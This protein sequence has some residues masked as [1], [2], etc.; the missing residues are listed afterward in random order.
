MFKKEH[1]QIREKYK[2]TDQANHWLNT[3][4]TTYLSA[5][6]ITFV[7]SMKYFFLATSSVD[8]M[9]NVNFKGTDGKGLIKVINPKKLIFADYDGNGILHS[10]GDIVSNPNI[11]MLVIDFAQDMRIKINGKATIIDNK[12]V[13]EK[14]LD[15]FESYNISRL[16]EVEIDYAIPNC[17]NN[18]AI[19]RESIK[20]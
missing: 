6:A 13:I 9:T 20:E 16:I 4:D 3:T 15:V 12:E 8:G 2:T 1:L 11:G 10:M 19:V 18:I 5:G 17:S 7:E 14:Y